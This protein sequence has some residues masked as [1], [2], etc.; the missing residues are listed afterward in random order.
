MLTSDSVLILGL[1]FKENCPDL[2]NSRAIDVVREL[3]RYN[4]V[5]DVYDPCVNPDD[6]RRE[7]ALE[8]VAEPGEGNYDAVIIAVGHKQF[9]DMGA[10]KLRSLCKPGGVL[11]DVKSLLPAEAGD[12]RREQA[13]NSPGT[14]SAWK[15]PGK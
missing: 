15:G 1:T 6:V 13:E 11:Y 7:Y 14:V 12:A 10:G 9:S 2:R 4:V 8:M 3:L 5:V